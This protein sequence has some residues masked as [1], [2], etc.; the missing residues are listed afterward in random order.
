VYCRV[1]THAHYIPT[2][3]AVMHEAPS[4]L[5]VQRVCVDDDDNDVC[6]LYHGCVCCVVW[7][8]RCTMR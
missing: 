3:Q 7:C 8:G 4:A 6:S 2:P 5:R 1:L